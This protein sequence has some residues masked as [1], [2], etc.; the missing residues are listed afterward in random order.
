MMV[1]AFTLVAILAMAALSIDVAELYV[2]R[3]E[4]QRAADAAALAGAKMFVTSGFTSVQG[5]TNV[6]ATDPTT[7][8]ATGPAGSTAAA[9][10]Q[11]E[12]VATQ[13]LIAGQPAVVTSITCDI[14]DAANPKITVSVTRTGVPTFFAKILGYISS[15]VN[16]TATAEAY[17]PSG[18][19]GNPEAMPIAT[20]IKPW[21]VPNCDPTGAAGS[22]N[23]HYFIDATGN[24][25]SH[26][27]SVIGQTIQLNLIRNGHAV[28]TGT[29]G[30]TLDFY[31]LNIPTTPPTTPICPSCAAGIAYI[32]N[33]ACTP[34]FL[35]SCGQQIG[36]ASNPL[37]RIQTGFTA[38]LTGRTKSGGQCLIH[39]NA[40]GLSTLQDTLISPGPPVVIH[41]G[42]ANPNPALRGVDNISRSDSIVTVPLY[43]DLSTNPALCASPGN[44]TGNTTVTGFLQLA[45]TQTSATAGSQIQGVVLNAS[46]CSAASIASYP[47]SQPVT[48]SG[49]SPVPVRLIHN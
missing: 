10:V 34:Q 40:D 26:I 22:C 30:N 14:S 37:I 4:A 41:G 11:A 25:A 27:P 31:P 17:N 47:P 44:C 8:C 32:Q 15:N 45:I 1:V 9:N 39:T 46:G 33:I 28:A 16:A 29:A 2:S 36:P 42:E 49:T 24:I 18:T 6:M 20:A 5:S 3:G 48:G 21:L 35:F 7:V 43:Q 23:D 19:V 38:Q 12:A 13:N